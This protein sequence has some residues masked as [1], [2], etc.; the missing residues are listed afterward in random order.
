MYLTVSAADTD[1]REPRARSS[2]MEA[3]LGGPWHT[4]LEASMGASLALAPKHDDSYHRTSR[5]QN[6]ITP[7]IIQNAAKRSGQWS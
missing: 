4:P 5:L 3:C 1:R 7:K 2:F 6:R